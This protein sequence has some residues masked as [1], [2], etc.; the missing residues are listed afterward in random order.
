[1]WKLAA[2]V[3]DGRSYPLFTLLHGRIG[4]SHDD[5][6]RVAATDIYFDF[7]QDAVK[8]NDST[9]EYLRQHKLPSPVRIFRT[10][11]GLSDRVMRFRHEQLGANRMVATLAW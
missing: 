11:N 9:T 10:R 4:Q 2:R 3:S 8:P 1:M 7:D 6:A 5:H